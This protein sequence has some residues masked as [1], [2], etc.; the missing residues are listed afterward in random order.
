MN[1]YSFDDGRDN[2]DV[3]GGFNIVLG[4]QHRGG[5]FTELKVG[6]IDSPNMKFGVGY[7]FR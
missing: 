5:L 3:G 6:T 2:G 4:A 1:I 7:V